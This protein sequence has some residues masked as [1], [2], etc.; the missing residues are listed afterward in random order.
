MTTGEYTPGPLPAG[1]SP[2]GAKS[3]S[4]IAGSTGRIILCDCPPSGPC[5]A[6]LRAIG[7]D[8]QVTDTTVEGEPYA[9]LGTVGLCSPVA[10]LTA[11]HQLLCDRHD[12]GDPVPFLRHLIRDA[13]GELI[14]T[15]DTDLDGNP[16]VVGGLAE[17]CTSSPST[18]SSAPLVLCSDGQPF[19]RHVVYDAE[20]S[21][22]RVFDTDPDGSPFTPTEVGTCEPLSVA[23]YPVCWVDADGEIIEQA[24]M[25]VGFSNNGARAFTRY[26]SLSTGDDLGSPGAGIEIRDCESGATV[27]GVSVAVTLVCAVLG[28]QSRT[29]L[30]REVRSADGSVVV[31]F[32]GNDGNVVVPT[33][34]TPGT[35]V[36]STATHLGTVCYSPPV[37]APVQ[38]LAVAD[39]AMQGFAFNK[40]SGE[41]LCNVVPAPTGET[42]WTLS[43]GCRN[44]SVST[45]TLAW[46]GPLTSVTLEYGSASSSN[47]DGPV[48]VQFGSTSTGPVTWDASHTPMYVGETRPS[49]PLL[50]GRFARLT[51]L[52]GPPGGNG[53]RLSGGTSI[54]LHGADTSNVAPVRFRVD[55]YGPGSVVTDVVGHAVVTRTS[56]GAVVYTDSLTGTVVDPATVTFSHCAE[57]AASGST[58]WSQARRV[59]P[60]NP[61]TPSGDL[62]GAATSVSATG[63]TGTW[64]V[65]DSDGTVVA[66]LPAG[67]SMTWGSQDAS[68]LV[69]PNVIAADAGGVVVVNWTQRLGT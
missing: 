23:A 52:S 8:G 61:W 1:A 31:D 58:L 63:V 44:P 40:T 66:G 21:L 25:E 10:P 67:L 49:R 69:P 51:Y 50:G 7:D 22:Q 37:A 3:A 57:T 68:N 33:Q 27:G 34:W 18:G 15:Y 24:L 28:G 2:C 60:G 62:L 59:E 32:V 4:S 47:P 46:N 5:V 12:D 26:T 29:V 11:S 16:Y 38:P 48:V 43:G 14:T 64:Q 36:V 6:F 9:P 56:D 55:F 13:D 41:D 35:C 45:P 17:P 30:R 65:T 20:G 54:L 19:V 42:G 39:L 53:P